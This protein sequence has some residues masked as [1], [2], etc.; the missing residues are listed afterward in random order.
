MN[1]FTAND[2]VISAGI[3]LTRDLPACEGGK[4]SYFVHV[5]PDHFGQ[6]KSVDE[7]LASGC[8]H[9]DGDDVVVDRCLFV[10]GDLQPEINPDG[11]ALVLGGIDYRQATFTDDV[12]EPSNYRTA[13]GVNICFHAVVQRHLNREKGHTT[14]HERHVFLGLFG[15]GDSFKT[16]ILFETETGERLNFGVSNAEVLSY[17]GGALAFHQVPV[18]RR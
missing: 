6:V 13:L 12:S 3:R 18:T 1:C 16:N 11:R 4:P 8:A 9:M 2:G 17:R 5:Q 7:L 14:G 10:G 15:E